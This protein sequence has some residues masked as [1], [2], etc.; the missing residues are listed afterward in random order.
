MATQ[1][2]APPNNAVAR[3][4][5]PTGLATVQNLLEKFKGQIQV[6]LPKHMTPER[7]IRVALTAMSQNPLLQKCD[8]LTVCASVV[9]ASILGLEPNSAL[10]EAYLIPFWNHKGNGGRGGYDCQ[11]QIGYKGH[12]KLARNSGEIAMID[13]QP[14]FEADEFDCE[15]GD[16]PYLKHKWAKTGSR[17]KIIGYWAGF[18]TKD[19][20]F[21]FE[22]WPLEQIYEHRDK[23]SQGAYKRERGKVVLDEKGQKVLQGPWKDSPDW[24]CRKTVLIQALKLAPKSVHL[25]TAIALD[26]AH[27]AGIRQQFS[28]DVPLELQPPVE[29][30]DTDPPLQEPQ[31]TGS[32]EAAPKP[33]TTKPPSILD[34]SD[35]F[36]GDT[37]LWQKV[38]GVVYHL[39]SDGKGYHKH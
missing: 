11:L 19:G 35:E 9:Q 39:N 26:E 34:D 21:S 25:A 29:A 15:K 17:G 14:V 12:T 13:A 4:Q 38:K 24:M 5:A 37:L 1:T 20:T 33:C 23:Y 27:D 32:S 30:E 31:R 7:M 3:Q 16:S 2:T 8:P 22:Y 36:D 6:A 18:K 10:G 28:I